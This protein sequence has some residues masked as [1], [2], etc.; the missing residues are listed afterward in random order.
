M[1]KKWLALLLTGVLMCSSAGTI[2]VHAS[3][4]EI[5]AIESQRANAQ[6]NLSATQS[7][8]SSLEAARQEMQNYLSELNGQYEALTAEISNL[9]V[10]AGQKEEDLKKVQENLASAK[11]ASDEQ[12][13]NMKLRM[14][15]LF[16][17]GSTNAF[18]ML[19]SSENVADFLNRAENIRQISNYDRNMLEK[20]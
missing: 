15:Y 13:E 12:Y 17:N 19:L 7:Q 10:Q 9:S 4:E 8:I 1:N 11:V 6:A 16:E 14:V 18:S 3:Q 5:A 2:H 20:Y